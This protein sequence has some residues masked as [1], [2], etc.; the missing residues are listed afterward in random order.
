MSLR[1]RPIAEEEPVEDKSALPNGVTISEVF[2][3]SS[4]G[5][6]G[7][8]QYF[9]GVIAENLVSTITMRS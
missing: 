7:G 9:T 8:P 2:R 6:W 5:S 1:F 4:M 3:S